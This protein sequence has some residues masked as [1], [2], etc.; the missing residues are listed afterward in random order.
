MN[1]QDYKSWTSFADHPIFS[2]RSGSIT[3]WSSDP[4]VYE[5]VKRFPTEFNPDWYV[6][7]EPR[8]P[9][10]QQAK[11]AEQDIGNLAAACAVLE[12]RFGELSHELFILDDL[13]VYVHVVVDSL[14][15][16]I[17]PLHLHDA[18]HILMLFVESPIEA[19]ELEFDAVEQIVP[20]LDTLLENA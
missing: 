10:D 2:D 6:H 14:T 8:L 15:V 13:T 16:D 5:D 9:T 7:Q 4:S 12:N 11:C 19:E 20:A 18:G 1:P 3:A 17:Y